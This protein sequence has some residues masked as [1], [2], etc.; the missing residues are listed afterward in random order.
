MRSTNLID[1]Q[2]FGRTLGLRHWSHTRTV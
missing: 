2:F 1:C